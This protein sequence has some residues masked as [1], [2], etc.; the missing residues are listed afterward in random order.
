MDFNKPSFKFQLLVY[1]PGREKPDTVYHFSEGYEVS[2]SGA[3]TFYQFYRDPDEGNEGKPKKVAVASYPAGKWENCFLVDQF[4]NY[5]ALNANSKK[6]STMGGTPSGSESYSSHSHS[7]NDESSYNYN[8]DSSHENNQS[9]E[10]NDY[11]SYNEPTFSPSSE[12]HEEKNDTSEYQSHSD[13]SSSSSDGIIDLDAPSHYSSSNE[14]NSTPSYD[15]NYNEDNSSSASTSNSSDDYSTLDSF[16]S[17][18]PTHTEH[19]SSGHETSHT[20]SEYDSPNHSSYSSSNDAPFETNS[21]STTTGTENNEEVSIDS[22]Y[23]APTP[24]VPQ[25]SSYESTPASSSNTTNSNS[26]NSPSTPSSSYSSGS[27]YGNSNSSNANS[28]PSYNNNNKF[29]KGG[30]NGQ[31]MS[32]AEMKALKENFLANSIISYMNMKDKI[33]NLDEIVSYATRVNANNIRFNPDDVVLVAYNLIKDKKV[34][35][36]KY[37]AKE[38]QKRLN[39]YLPPI[40]KRH[41]LE[42]KSMLVTYLNDKEET[43]DMNL[44][45]LAAWL[46]YNG[47]V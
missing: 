44:L 43:K 8:S 39:L 19:Q 24:S 35:P 18:G 42:K 13:S 23:N 3:I 47:Y 31:Q 17:D 11:S 34:S 33:F 1:K 9:S 22:I 12:E 26:Y 15:Y 27:S 25:T 10:Q 20:S 14:E 46:V 29:N 45:D 4:N 28:K 40:I 38:K 21:N 30:N 2:A 32:F 36:E 7:N 5:L 37:T 41:G 16:L 6:Y